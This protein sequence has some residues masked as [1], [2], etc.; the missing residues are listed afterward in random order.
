MRN[1]VFFQIFEKKNKKK[2]LTY[3]SVKAVSKSN[4]KLVELEISS[5]PLTHIR[6]CLQAF[7]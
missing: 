2:N 1:K 3:H 6:E 5:L 4:R 7:P